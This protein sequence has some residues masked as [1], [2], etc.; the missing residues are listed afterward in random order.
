[1]K[2]ELLGIH[3]PCIPNSSCNM[4]HMGNMVNNNRDV[5]TSL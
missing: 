4:A 1:M 2:M 5:K 3:G